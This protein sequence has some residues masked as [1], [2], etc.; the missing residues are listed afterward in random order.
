ME[1][2][3]NVTAQIEDYKEDL[4]KL[5]DR[6]QKLM[7]RYVEQFSVMESVV[8]NSKSMRTSLTSSFEG[9]MNAYK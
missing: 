3:G 4:Q 7:S 8:G 5:E 2:T 1:Q 9:M 6:M